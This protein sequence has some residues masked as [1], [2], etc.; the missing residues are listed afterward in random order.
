[1]VVDDDEVV[2]RMETLEQY[3]FLCESNENEEKV[4]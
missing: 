4:R 1:M 3:E 2:R